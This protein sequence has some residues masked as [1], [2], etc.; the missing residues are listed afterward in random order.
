MI[1]LHCRIFADMDIFVPIRFK[2][3][4]QLSPADL[5]DD[6]KTVITKKLQRNLEGVCTRYGY[7]KPGSIDIVKRSIGSFMKQNFNAHIRFEVVC[8][9]DVCN[10]P[11][12]STLEAIVKNK[13]A[14]G[15]HAESY[16]TID[17]KEQPVLDVIVP[18]KSAGIISEV[19]LDELDIGHKINVEV[20]GKRYQLNDKKISI[21]AKA[22]KDPK[23]RKILEEEVADGDLDEPVQEGE[24]DDEFDE[25]ESDNEKTESDEESEKEVGGEFDEDVEP[26]ID[27][28]E[29]A[30]EDFEEL[31]ELESELESDIDDVDEDEGSALF[32]EYD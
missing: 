27:K 25:V 9:A 7:I 12:G 5:V 20:L 14:L 8:K 19:N 15:I 10:P 16:L 4:V 26:K 29:D 28:N 2:T 1:W 13:N 31:E 32:D 21:I 24:F 22:I 23:E 18:K 11:I 3:T 17:G 6:F 30:E